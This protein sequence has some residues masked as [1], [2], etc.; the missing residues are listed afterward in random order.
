MNNDA[1]VG[2]ALIICEGG[3][4]TELRGDRILIPLPTS[5]QEIEK[6]LRRLKIYPLMA[7]FRGQPPLAVA[8]VV[9][10]AMAINN[11]AVEHQHELVTLDINPLLVSENG[12]VAVDQ[13]VVLRG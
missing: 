13:L 10:A 8:A 4:L 1:V 5:E 9:A 3:V 12:A 6:S 11:F 7:G 2:M